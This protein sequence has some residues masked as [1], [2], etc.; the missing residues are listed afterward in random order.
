MKAYQGKSTPDIKG[1][2][3]D[4]DPSLLSIGSTDQSV[5]IGFYGTKS[6]N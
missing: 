4:C 6:C 1:A 2:G 3:N 5:L